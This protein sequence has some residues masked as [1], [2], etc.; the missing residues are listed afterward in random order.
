MNEQVA[1]L[2]ADPHPLNAF[3]DAVDLT[4]I[5]FFAALIG[6][7]TATY[8][9]QLWTMDRIRIDGDCWVAFHLRRLALVGIALA[10]L[11]SISYSSVSGWHPWP[12]DVLT[13]VAIDALLVSAIIVAVRRKRRSPSA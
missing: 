5:H 12:P 13:I 3:A 10:M 4:G 9:M 1:A 11:W 7:L 8:V 2:M 6:A